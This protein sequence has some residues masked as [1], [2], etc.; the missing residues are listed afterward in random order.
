MTS[1]SSKTCRG[2]R[3]TWANNPLGEAGTA[4]AARQPLFHL[5]L[6]CVIRVIERVF[7]VADALLHLALNLVLEPFD[8][9]LVAAGQLAAF[10]LHFASD[11][12]HTALDLVFVHHRLHRMGLRLTPLQ[13]ACL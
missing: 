2:C 11:V 13:P 12:L 9:L 10:L 8:L 6:A 7:R 1:S 3:T 5:R 4:A